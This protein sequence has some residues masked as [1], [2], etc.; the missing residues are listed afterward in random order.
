MLHDLPWMGIHEPS[1]LSTMTCVRERVRMVPPGPTTLTSLTDGATCGH[2]D[3]TTREAIGNNRQPH[4]RPRGQDGR[5]GGLQR[6]QLTHARI[7]AA[8]P[9]RTC[10]SSLQPGASILRLTAWMGGAEPRGSGWSSR[11]GD[12]AQYDMTMPVMFWIRYLRRTDT[13]ARVV[14]NYKRAGHV[15]WGRRV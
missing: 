5:A 4:E 11:S 14:T 2:S 8:S 1:K 12:G 10:S 15:A 9:A 13:V 3:T 7:P 6:Q